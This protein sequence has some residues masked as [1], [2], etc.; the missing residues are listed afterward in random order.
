MGTPLHFR[1]NII[2]DVQRG[3][4]TVAG[5]KPEDNPF[6]PGAG[7]VPEVWVGRDGLLQTH[8]A[9]RWERLR[10]RYTTGTVF[11]GPSGIGKS[12]L[13]NRFAEHASAAGDVVVEAVRVAKR[14]DPIA[15]LAGAVDA[16]ARQVAG[17]VTTADALEALLA[18]L[19]VVSIKGVRLAIEEEGIANPHLVVRDSLLELGAS[20][21][22]EN[23]SRPVERQRVVVV[24]LDELQ[25]ASNAQRSA[26]LSALG[27]V[28][29]HQVEVG[30]RGGR[31]NVYLPVL[32][33]VTGLPDLLNRATNVDTFRRRFDT[34]QLGVLDDA[35]VVD[36]LL[37]TPLP[38]GVRVD[39]M[40]AAAFADVVAGDPYLFQLVGQHAWNASAGPVI[41]VDDVARADEATY[42]ERLRAVEAASSDI[43]EAE[44]RVLD[45]IYALVDAHGQVTGAQVA[46]HL[47]T[48]PPQIATAAQRLERR[49]A[50]RRVRGSWRI[51][52]RL[53]HRY[54][55]TGDVVAST[56]H[57]VPHP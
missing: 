16:A 40:A 29:E 55:T 4:A 6:R 10:G 46:A 36:A 27:D 5:R 35:E 25:N 28:L 56:G 33:Y 34:I 53:L 43:P 54:R 7:A 51:E 22:H 11:I 57:D 44:A 20:L 39:P 52:H 18:R 31:G 38:S 30:G 15:Q 45:A 14:S 49:A 32:L 12:V 23:H 13:V 37:T 21:A 42:G 26:L 41:E 17:R 47:G 9:R 19:Q 24:R 1:D 48:S 8:D 3:V 2:T 50:I